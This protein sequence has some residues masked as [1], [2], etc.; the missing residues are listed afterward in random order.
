MNTNE[1]LL[2]RIADLELALQAICLFFDQD[3]LDYVS[4]SRN[5]WKDLALDM[6]ETARVAL[7]V[8]ADVIENIKNNHFFDR[9]EALDQWRKKS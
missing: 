4:K 8:P 5:A 6:A 1:Q 3:N 7:G 2:A 9:D